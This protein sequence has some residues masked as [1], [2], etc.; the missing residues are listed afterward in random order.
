MRHPKNKQKNILRNIPQFVQSITHC[1]SRRTRYHASSS[2][3]LSRI[4]ELLKINSVLPSQASCAFWLLLRLDGLLRAPSPF[5]S[6]WNV[7]ILRRFSWWFSILQVLILMCQPQQWCLAP[8]LKAS[9]PPPLHPHPPSTPSWRFSDATQP[10]HPGLLPGFSTMQEV[11]FIP[12]CYHL[13][14]SHTH[15]VSHGS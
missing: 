2:H 12:L 10:A 9:S 14:P 6:T 1:Q 13:I 7:F 11:P 4:Q 3:W 5:P 8:W 15:Y